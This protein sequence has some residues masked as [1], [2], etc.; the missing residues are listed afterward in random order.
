VQDALTMVSS[1]ECR[2]GCPACV[3]PILASDE[4]RGYSPKHLSTQIL[5]MLVNTP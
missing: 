5:S 3:G 4:T 2:Y 1:C